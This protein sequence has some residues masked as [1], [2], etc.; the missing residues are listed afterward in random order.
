MVNLSIE[1]PDALMC[2]RPGLWEPLVGNDPG[3]P[4]LRYHDRDLRRVARLGKA[5][6]EVKREIRSQ[7]RKRVNSVDWLLRF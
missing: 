7:D 2:A 3:P 1:E 4:G 5:R 6:M